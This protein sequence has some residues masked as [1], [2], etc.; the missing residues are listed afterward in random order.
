[1]PRPLTKTARIDWRR[2]ALLCLLAA[3]CLAA[4]VGAMAGETTPAGIQQV[5][6]D[7]HAKFEGV[8]DG[9][10]ADYI[11]ALDKVDPELFGIAAFSP[12]LDAAGNSVRAQ[13]AIDY[14]AERLG[15][16]IFE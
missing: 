14:I 2:P 15:G 5:L 6:E 13:L 1:M 10:N 8:R 12:R 4:A 11:P 9:A 7:A 16:N 3:C